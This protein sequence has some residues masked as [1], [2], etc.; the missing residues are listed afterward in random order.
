M[1]IE[2]PQWTDVVLPVSMVLGATGSILIPVKYTQL[3]MR[4]GHGELCY[5][6]G[7]GHLGGKLEIT[8]SMRLNLVKQ[9][10]N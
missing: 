9:L 8:K 1:H 6:R 10:A 7:Y 4:W 3:S 2:L 5:R